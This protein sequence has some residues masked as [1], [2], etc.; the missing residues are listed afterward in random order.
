MA[1]E[2]SSKNTEQGIAQLQMFE[3]NLKNL[4]MQRQNFQMHITETETALEELEKTN[5]NP[6]KIVGGIM[7][8]STKDELKKELTSRKEIVELRIKNL[9]KQENQLK[10]RADLLQKSVLKDLQTE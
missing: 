1:K 7:I 8:E 3:M 4:A 9:E 2:K 6:F 10:E 5:N